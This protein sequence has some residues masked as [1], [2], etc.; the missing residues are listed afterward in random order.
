M[1]LLVN[2]FNPAA[3]NGVMCRD[4]LSVGWDGSIYDCDFNQQLAIGLGEINQPL[5]QETRAAP[6]DSRKFKSVYDVN[7]VQDILE[8]PIAVD[9]HCFGCT[10]GAGSSCQGTVA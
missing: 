2:N 5:D 1:T 8:E 4:T 7:S 10:A 6:S 3:V 9:L